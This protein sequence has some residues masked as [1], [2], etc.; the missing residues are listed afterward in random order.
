ME[1]SYKHGQAA[2]RGI[3]IKAFQE[4]LNNI[5]KVYHGNWKDLVPDGIYGRNTRDAVKQFQ[6]MMNIMPVTGNMDL[7][8]QAAIDYS[9]SS[10][11]MTYNFMK[12]P[13]NASFGNSNYTNGGD[14]DW[15]S[16][17]QTGS[18]VA[19]KITATP[20]TYGKPTKNE[21]VDMWKGPINT[22]LAD[23]DA[24]ADGII[25]LKTIQ[26]QKVLNSIES[27]I[28]T[29]KA[30][31]DKM[32]KSL[33][34]QVEQHLIKLSDLEDIVKTE[35]N[36]KATQETQ[37]VTAA[38]IKALGKPAKVAKGFG[39]VAIASQFLV[40][41]YFGLAWYTCTPGQEKQAK[42]DFVNAVGSFFGS[43]LS[44][45]IGKVLQII[46]TRIAA[47]F[48]AGSVVPGAG[49]LVGTIVGIAIA[50]I[51]IVLYILTGNTIGDWIWE[52]IKSLANKININTTNRWA[53]LDLSTMTPQQIAYL[54]PG[55][56]QMTPKF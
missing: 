56:I 30:T 33:M 49:N 27:E 16:Y 6:I 50:V 2:Q 17:V 15:G 41:V 52:G 14:M 43:L 37:K 18:T 10:S 25:E 31:L 21:F 45:A 34:K 24:I 1:Y 35:G 20:S 28:N 53:T 19:A 29:I 38:R 36:L 7:R 48:V 26:I 12:P 42:E 44:T 46:A 22:F 8:T 4:K 54:G 55:G 51:D 39:F 47:G 32:S 13:V 11:N 23:I 5:R 9:F 40:V 3:E